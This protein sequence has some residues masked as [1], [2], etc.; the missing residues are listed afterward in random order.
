MPFIGCNPKTGSKAPISPCHVIVF[1]LSAILKQRF[2]S[3][4]T[5]V[6]QPDAEITDRE[7]RCHVNFH[8]D[9]RTIGQP[10]EQRNTLRFAM[11]G[12]CLG[13]DA[14]RPASWLRSAKHWL[15][16]A[17]RRPLKRSCFKRRRLSRLPMRTLTRSTAYLRTQCRAINLYWR[18]THPSE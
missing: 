3:L 11:Y 5:I 12:A 7:C 14:N 16:L 10:N 1:K 15:R 6:S 4:M 9:P 8:I 17:S 18:T 2:N 13:D